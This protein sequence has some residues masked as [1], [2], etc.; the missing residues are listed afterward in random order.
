[1]HND[2]DPRLTAF[3][4]GM[5]YSLLDRMRAAILRLDPVFTKLFCRL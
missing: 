5:R 2:R 3:W 4:A 1:M